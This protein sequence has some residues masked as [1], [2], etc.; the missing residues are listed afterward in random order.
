M[1]IK[2]PKAQYLRD[3]PD[4]LPA[5][6]YHRSLTVATPSTVKHPSEPTNHNNSA[7]HINT[8]IANE[9]SNS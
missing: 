7:D 2:E 5:S 9:Q 8:E 6:K 4:I 1:I 3:E